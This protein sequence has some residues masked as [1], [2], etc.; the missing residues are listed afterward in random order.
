MQKTKCEYCQLE[1]N[2]E[3]DN[4]VALVEFE[5]DVYTPFIESNPRK[6][7]CSVDCVYLYIKEKKGFG[8]D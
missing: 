1:I 4:Y 7:F 3:K 5:P 2:S 6:E 8:G